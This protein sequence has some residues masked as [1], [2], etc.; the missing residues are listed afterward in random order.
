MANFANYDS[1]YHTTAMSNWFQ[2]LAQSTCTTTQKLRYCDTV[3]EV[4]FFSPWIIV[5][6]LPWWKLGPLLW[7]IYLLTYSDTELELLGSRQCLR[8]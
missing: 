2:S 6:N 5:I 1:E 4:V 7:L 3:I 8:V